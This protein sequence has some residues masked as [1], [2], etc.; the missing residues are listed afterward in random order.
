MGVVGVMAEVEAQGDQV[1]SGLKGIEWGMNRQRY[2][3]DGT[4]VGSWTSIG[5]KKVIGSNAFHV[6]FN[7][8]DGRGGTKGGCM[9]TWRRF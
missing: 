7:G 1:A 4:V 8:Q 2:A 6:S 3:Y 5:S 9:Y